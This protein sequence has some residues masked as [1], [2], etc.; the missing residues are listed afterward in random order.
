ML[1]LECEGADSL[2]VELFQVLFK[3]IRYVLTFAWTSQLSCTLTLP[4]TLSPTHLFLFPLI[5]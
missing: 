3:T 1:D 2:V 4:A 5:D